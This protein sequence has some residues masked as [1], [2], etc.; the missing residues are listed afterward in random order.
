MLS[1]HSGIRTRGSER[2]GPKTIANKDDR[3]C[4]RESSEGELLSVFLADGQRYISQRYEKA[5]DA[6]PARLVGQVEALSL[7]SEGSSDKSGPVHGI[8]FG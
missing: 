4:V 3:H 8:H 1:W 7:S 2:F 5:A 6:Q